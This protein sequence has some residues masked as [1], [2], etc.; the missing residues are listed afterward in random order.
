MPEISVIVPFYN[1]VYIQYALDSLIR[2]TERD[3]EIILVD[4]GSTAYQELLDPYE[5]HIRYFRKENG[6]TATALNAGIQHATGKYF[7]WLSSDDLYSPT[8]LS[9]QKEFMEHK[10]APISYTS[11]GLIGEAHTLQKDLFQKQFNNE[12]QFLKELNQRCIIHGNAVMMD[13]DVF[14]K[15]GV[16][17]EQ[18]RYTHDY[19]MWLRAA[20]HYPFAFLNETLVYYRIHEKMGTNQHK[21]EIIQE[22]KKL[23]W[24]YK[25][26]Y[27]MKLSSLSKAC[28]TKRPL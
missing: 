22:L 16:F 24:E 15:I 25:E 7:T 17:N 6:G 18:F 28:D 1:C 5:K 13:M 4:D 3:F 23:R 20:L 26:K 21:E 10:Q 14:S 11:A 8:K 12:M 9:K 19:E 27:R 2:Q